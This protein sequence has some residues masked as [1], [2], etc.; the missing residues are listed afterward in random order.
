MMNVTSTF[1]YVLCYEPY[2]MCFVYVTTHK[3]FQRL[4]K[5]MLNDL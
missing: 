4:Y 1:L 3:T 2:N 5:H